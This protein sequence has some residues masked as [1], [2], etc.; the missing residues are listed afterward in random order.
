[1][2]RAYSLA[3]SLLLT[4]FFTLLFLGFIIAVI[5][6]EDFRVEL[7]E[8]PGDDSEIRAA[9]LVARVAVRLAAMALG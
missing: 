5:A 7:E 3:R 4:A 9:L 1:M 6:S 8:D 2:H